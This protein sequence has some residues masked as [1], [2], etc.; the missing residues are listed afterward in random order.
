MV[1][2]TSAWATVVS[3][4]PSTFHLKYRTIS[5]IIIRRWSSKRSS[6]FTDNIFVIL[7]VHVRSGS[8]LKLRCDVS[9]SRLVAAF[10]AALVNASLIILLM[11]YHSVQGARVTWLF[12]FVS[13]KNRRVCTLRSKKNKNSSL[14]NNNESLNKYI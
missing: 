1:V 5:L 8:K 11:I 4:S 12:L 14:I 6:A 2:W 10:N 9:I 13:T 3:I 7:S